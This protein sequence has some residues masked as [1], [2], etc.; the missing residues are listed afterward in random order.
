MHCITYMHTYLHTRTNEFIY[1]CVHPLQHT[2]IKKNITS[3]YNTTNHITIHHIT[4][5]THILLTLQ[6]IHTSHYI[7]SRQITSHCVTTKYVTYN[8]RIHW[9]IYKHMHTFHT[10]MRGIHTCVLV[11]VACTRD[12]VIRN[13]HYIHACKQ[14]MHTYMHT[15]MHASI[16]D[17]HA[18]HT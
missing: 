3:N 6:Y 18:L 2:R 17:M 10:G 14:Y 7:T 12:A 8:Q 15:R 4:Q 16:F 13:V 9:Y 5:T 1:T 11:C